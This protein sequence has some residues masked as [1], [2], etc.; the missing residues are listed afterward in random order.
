MQNLGTTLV[1]IDE[2]LYRWINQTDL[3]YLHKILFFLSNEQMV[4][5]FL[6]A[7][8]LVGLFQ[9]NKFVWRYLLLV[10]VI[11]AIND[12]FCYYVLKDQLGRLRPC[13]HLSPN[14]NLRVPGCGSQFGFPSN[15]AAN[16]MAFATFTFLYFRKSW[17]VVFF[18]VA[19]LAGYSRVY[20]GVHYLGD[21]IAG[22]LVGA[23]IAYTGYRI[24]KKLKFKLI[25]RS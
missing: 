2:K 17:M 20:I 19:L 5:Y 14:I 11:L 15:H 25:A 8:I 24:Q 12:A 13:I 10:L 6:G 9:R 3:P 1:A 7:L 4:P 21:V 22:F 23:L 16:S 18:I